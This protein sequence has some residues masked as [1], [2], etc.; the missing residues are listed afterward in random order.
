MKNIRIYSTCGEDAEWL[1]LTCVSNP[2][3]RTTKRYGQYFTLDDVRV[4]R[5]LLKVEVILRVGRQ[6]ALLTSL[7]SYPS[8]SPMRPLV[9]F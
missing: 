1:G 8:L 2:A 3:A 9:T 5:V 6:G 7:S 4:K